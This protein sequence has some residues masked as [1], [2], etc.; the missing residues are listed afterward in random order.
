MKENE[1]LQMPCAFHLRR[2]LPWTLAGEES[3]T[4]NGTGET[5]FHN[6]EVPMRYALGLPSTCPGDHPW[7]IVE[8]ACLAEAAG[9]DSVFIEDYI[10][11]WRANDAPTYD[12]WL[13]MT[14][15]AMRTQRIRLGITVT[16][17]SRRRPWKVAREA[18]TLDY[19]SHGR[20]VLGVGLG[21]VRE[22][23]FTHVGE[24]TDA[25]QRAKM[26]DEALEIVA[27]LWSGQPFSYQGV[28]YQVH[29]LIFLPIPLQQPR[30]PILVGASWPHKGPIRRAARW[31]GI[32][33]Y[34]YTSDGNWQDMT[35]EE[36]REL[37]AAVEAQRVVSTPFE[38]LYGGRRRGPDWEQERAL[39]HS[40]AQAGVT[41]WAEYIEPDDLEDLEACR[42]YVKQGPLRIE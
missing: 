1:T 30:I 42:Q 24:V 32:V 25:S 29:E 15:I 12:P 23:G 36:I 26:L 5:G 19:L 27:G 37:K 11:H 39:I 8:L 6:K 3:C 21:D 10:V 35:P 41:C 40:L 2:F 28:Y 7:P 38:I 20:F 31:D 33:P 4:G 14:A 22:P 17:L 34:K 16:P 18:V 9:W 13:T